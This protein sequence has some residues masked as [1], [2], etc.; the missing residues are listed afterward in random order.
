M[1]VVTKDAV[2]NAS[3]S[4]AVAVAIQYLQTVLTTVEA[5]RLETGDC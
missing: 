1:P 4:A 5:L 2:A 3:E